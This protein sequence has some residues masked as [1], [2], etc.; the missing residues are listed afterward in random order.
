M[1]VS[2]PRQRPRSQTLV[3]A[4]DKVTHCVRSSLVQRV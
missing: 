1:M 3:S 2:Q 4:K